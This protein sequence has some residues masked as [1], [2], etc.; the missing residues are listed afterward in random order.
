M[1]DLPLDRVSP[2]EPPFTYVE[3]DYFGPFGVK[4]GRTIVK[5]YG[6]I[7]TCLAIR[8][9]H[10]EMASSLETDPSPK[11]AYYRRQKNDYWILTFYPLP[12]VPDFALFCS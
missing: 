10:I 2:D 11:S 6:V 8:A 3:V 4:R 1:A 12:F 7:F 5:R 9:I